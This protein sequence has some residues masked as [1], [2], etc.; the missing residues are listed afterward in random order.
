MVLDSYNELASNT[1]NDRRGQWNWGGFEEWIA[2]CGYSNYLRGVE[3]LIAEVSRR[4]VSWSE[5]H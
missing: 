1:C 3:N 5:S 4:M 2:I